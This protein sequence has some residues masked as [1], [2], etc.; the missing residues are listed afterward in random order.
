[1]DKEQILE[2]I[3]SGAA[4]MGELRVGLS[5]MNTADIADIIKELDNEKVIGTF[6]ILPKAIASDVFSHMDSIDQQTI[7]ETLSDAEVGDIVDRLFVDD[8]VDLLEEMPA[9]VVARVLQNVHYE[10]RKII[11]QFLQY[12]EDSAGSI[13]T[14]EYVALPEDATV[15]EA[16]ATIR[17]GGVNK[18]T[19]YTCYVVRNDRFLAGVITARKLMLAGPDQRI[20]DLMEANVVFAGTTDDQEAVAVQ[21]R[22]YDLLA[23][24]VVDKDRML[25][26]I[27]TVDDIVDVIIEENTED[28]EKMAALSPSDAPYLDTGVFKLAKN[29]FLWLLVLML[30]AVLTGAAITSFEHGLAAMP[31]LMA[32]IPMLMDTGGNAGSQTAALIIRGM[33]VGEI[34]K[35]DIFRILWKEIRVALLCG[36][37]LGTVNFIRVFLMNGQNLLLCATITLTLCC[38]LVI[39]K[40]AGAVL[41]VVAKRFGID[42]AIMAAPLITTI[43]D[44]LSLLVY[45]AIART[46]L[47]L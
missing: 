5:G 30:S 12:P 43:A 29:R 21:F 11:N 15:Q 35:R 46:L 6:R 42:P 38:T 44:V 25:V 39:A 26:G 36:L 14:T 20:G 7:I 3:G 4:D 28:I 17:S 31:I 37:G 27:I 22:K 8:A 2:L 1:M 33:A 9:N 45:F 16:F 41:P 19:I 47:G 13:M 40:T 34:C 10:K 23:M 32:F 24:P 18:E